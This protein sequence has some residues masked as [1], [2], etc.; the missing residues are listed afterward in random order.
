MRGLFVTSTPMFNSP[1]SVSRRVQDWIGERKL[2][3]LVADLN[4]YLFELRLFLNYLARTGVPSSYALL[5]LALTQI[6]YRAYPAALRNCGIRL[7]EVVSGLRLQYRLLV[8]LLY[9]WLELGRW[10]AYPLTSP[11]AEEN[12][13]I[14]LAHRTLRGFALLLA[15]LNW[16]TAFNAQCAEVGLAGASGVLCGTLFKQSLRA[17]A[18]SGPGLEGCHLLEAVLAAVSIRAF[19]NVADAVLVCVWCV[20]GFRK[21]FFGL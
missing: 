4:C 21:G 14:A 16:T 8:A 17:M 12:A 10:C 20:L 7:G 11:E 5:W 13:H 3:R 1:A 19:G 9:Y 2:R 6:C 18:G 15:A